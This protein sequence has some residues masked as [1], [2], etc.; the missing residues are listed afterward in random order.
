MQRRL[1]GPSKSPT[2]VQVPL[3]P[4]MLID[5]AIPKAPDATVFLVEKPRFGIKVPSAVE[6]GGELVS[7]GTFFS[8][9]LIHRPLKADHLQR[10][11]TLQS[12]SK[13]THGRNQPLTAQTAGQQPHGGNES[14]HFSIASHSPERQVLS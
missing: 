14:Q 5:G 1:V 2:A 9:I 13:P 7:A 8:R 4:A 10:H 12:G 6:R 3:Q 11:F